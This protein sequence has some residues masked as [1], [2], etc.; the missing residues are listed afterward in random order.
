MSFDRPSNAI[1]TTTP[2][3]RPVAKSQLVRMLAELVVRDMLAEQSGSL[4]MSPPPAA[5]QADA[6]EGPGT[7]GGVA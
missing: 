2:E 1:P 7:K 3:R 4:A 6:A 5:T